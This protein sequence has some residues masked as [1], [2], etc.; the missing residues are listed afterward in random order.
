M[1]NVRSINNRRIA[2]NTVMLYIRMAVMCA[3]S[4]YTSRVV[5]Q[6][7]GVSD[8][9]IFS[10]VGGIIGVLNYV[11]TLLAGG[12]S[13][14]ITIALGS[15]DDKMLRRNFSTALFL[16]LFSGLVVLL[17]GE[18]IGIWFVNNN[19]N[20]PSDRIVALNWTYQCAL[21]AS[22]ITIIQSPFT[23]SVLSH[24]K[25]NVYAAISIFDS[26]L[27][28]GLISVLFIY[29]GDK[30]ILYSLFLLFVAIVDAILYIVYCYRSYPE[31]HQM[32]RAH[33]EIIKDM[34][35]YSG[36]NM[37]GGLA[38]VLTNYGVNVIINIFFGTIVNAG[39]GIAM[40][41]HSIVQQLYTNFQLASQPQMYKYYAQGEKESMFDLICNTSRYSA[42]LLLVFILPLA[43]NLQGI[44]R[45]WLGEVPDYSHGFTLL[46]FLNCFFFAIDGPLGYGIHAIGKM[47]LPNSL[48]AV[49]NMMVFPATYIVFKM[50]GSMYW[51]SA[52][53]AIVV[54][55]CIFVDCW[56]L[57]HLADFSFSQFAAQSLCPVIVVLLVSVIVPCILYRFNMEGWLYTIAFVSIDV[58]Y[59]ASVV[60][61]IGLPHHVRSMV[62]NKLLR[63]S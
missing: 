41:I 25:M 59:V 35:S 12:T 9:G 2:K 7:L 26:V 56:I 13:R 39:R 27:K 17:L 63:R 21:L 43:F 30:L 50:G 23:A 51:G 3:I 52:F 49:L 61:F 38:N 11:N 32:P 1:N 22:I 15:G 8:Y 34:F 28:L 53:A 10:V 46:A 44:L 57:H 47:R 40:Q 24:E 4:L 20:I 16:C 29:G 37:I 45:I 36:W 19:L 33:S 5:L 14:F 18:T 55:L 31:S 62:I 6:S 60:F 48:T 54:F 42:Y 58:I